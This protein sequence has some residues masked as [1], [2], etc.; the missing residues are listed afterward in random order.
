MTQHTIE[1]N[2]IHYSGPRRK[3]IL[4]AEWWMQV[5]SKY[6]FMHHILIAIG[7]VTVLSFNGL[8]S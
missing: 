5:Y 4:E 6:T 1:R 7:M 3:E 2:G 8:T